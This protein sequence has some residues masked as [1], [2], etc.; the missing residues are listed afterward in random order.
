MAE[1][2]AKEDERRWLLL[3]RTRPVFSFDDIQELLNVQ[4]SLGT[5]QPPLSEGNETSMEG[6]LRTGTTFLPAGVLFPS[7]VPLSYWNILTPFYRRSIIIESQVP[8]AAP[9]VDV[10]LNFANNNV[11]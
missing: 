4:N 2:K 9:L 3:F 11:S 10:L 6:L 8:S 5:R 1:K 7:L